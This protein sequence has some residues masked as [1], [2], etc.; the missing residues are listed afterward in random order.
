MT[1]KQSRKGIFRYEVEVGV[2]KF[3]PKRNEKGIAL[4]RSLRLQGG[5]EENSRERLETNGP[6]GF[7]TGMA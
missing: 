7:M 1:Q 4:F 2:K 3:C 6:G 5:E